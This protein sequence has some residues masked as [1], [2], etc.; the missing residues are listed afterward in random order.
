MDGKR[1]K[2]ASASARLL[3]SPAADDS[4]NQPQ[5]EKGSATYTITYAPNYQQTHALMK[6]ADFDRRLTL[7][8]KTIGIGS[9]TLPEL[10]S[11][12]LPRAIMPTLDTLQKK[13]SMLSEASVASLDSI[14]RRARTLTQEADNLTKARQSAKHAKEA[15]DE[16]QVPHND[17]N[18][19]STEQATKINALY[20]T[21]PTIEGLAPLLPPL[22]DRLRSLRAIHA[23]AARAGETLGRIEARQL[24]IT[25]DIKI[26][27][28]GLESVE[29]AIE[30]GETAM[31]DNKKVIER[32]VKD[33]EERLKKLE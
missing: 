8:E 22:L 19:E 28:E 6:A 31:N 15:L 10:E 13:I 29:K 25:E 23:D 16:C 24:E 26:W 11:I 20:G 4:D 1:R 3:Q 21:L 2:S 5:L 33:L 14:T 27:K 12:S 17:P 30:E 32:W 7:L 9:S 18:S